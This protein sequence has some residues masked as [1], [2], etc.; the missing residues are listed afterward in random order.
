MSVLP[1]LG[2]PVPAFEL[3]DEHGTPVSL[4]TL[5]GRLALLV[6]FPHA[7]TPTCDGELTALQASYDALQE[8][9]G[10][11]GVGIVGVC[12]D[13]D[14]AL[15]EF[16]EQHDLPF[17]LLSDFWPHGA[18]AQAYGAFFESR[19]FATRASFLVDGDG[20]LRWS[21]VNGPGE[22]RDVDD[23]VTAL[24]ELAGAR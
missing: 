5:A 20:I 2:R 23:Y 22:A 1:D 14:S 7:F 12:C 19:G 24:H 4:E 18:V 16:S 3:A 13:P 8:A 6:F 15:R 21:V 10:P 9:A 11:G 17:A